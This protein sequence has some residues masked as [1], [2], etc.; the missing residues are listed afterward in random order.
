MRRNGMGASVLVV[1]AGDLGR[2]FAAMLALSGVVDEL[3]LAGLCQGQGPELAATLAQHYDVRARFIELDGTRQADVERLLRQRR[4]DLVVQ[5][6]TLLGPWV[7]YQRSDPVALAIRKA[8]LAVQLPAQLPV[9]ATLMRAVREVGY[10]GPV[11]SISYPDLTHEVLDRLGLAP[12]IG[13]GNATIMHAR[14]RAALRDRARSGGE[15]AKA[16][17]VRLVTD[18][19]HNHGAFTCAPPAAAEDRCR[20]YLGEAGERADELAYAGPPLRISPAVN[21]IA[22]ATSMPVLRALLPGGPPTR[23][24]APAPG[25]L[26]GGYPVRIEDGR[27]S[28]DLPPGVALEESKAFNVRI[29]RGDGVE[30]VADDG[31]VFY[32]EAAKSAVAAIDP[33]L[34]EPLRPQDA[35]PRAA[36]LIARL[37]A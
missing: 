20:V 32:T 9:L 36:R 13:L 29:R 34:C 18:R 5:S 7:A 28:L 33:G 1:G 25:G 31:T 3:T 35:P 17:I 15:G 21:T 26:P 19:F 4:P 14:V 23:I 24:S 8:G 22:A 2:Q 10:G 12:T 30:R 16:P 27:V 6:A 11:A 37:N